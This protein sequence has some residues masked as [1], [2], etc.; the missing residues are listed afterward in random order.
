MALDRTTA[1]IA[2][3][4]EKTNRWKINNEPVHE[5]VNTGTCW[6]CKHCGETQE[7]DVYLILGSKREVYQHPGVCDMGIFREGGFDNF[8]HHYSEKLSLLQTQEK[9]WEKD[10]FKNLQQRYK[11]NIY[12]C[13]FLQKYEFHQYTELA[14]DNASFGLLDC[15]WRI[16]NWSAAFDVLCG[17]YSILYRHITNEQITSL[18]TQYVCD[19]IL[20][21]SC[22]Q[23]LLDFF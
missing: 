1:L 23:H 3:K 12:I 7:R 4:D 11:N 13:L 15:L 10:I 5:W 16:Y 6:A 2:I 9:F 21:T 19:D 22:T 18:I 20:L 17:K 14:L 8:I